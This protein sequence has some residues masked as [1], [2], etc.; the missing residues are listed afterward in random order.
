AITSWRRGRSPAL[1]SL[2]CHTVRPPRC[3]RR[4]RFRHRRVVMNRRG[5]FATATG[6]AIA[7]TVP[8]SGLVAAEPQVRLRELYEKDM[9]FTPFAL[10]NAGRRVAIEGFMAPP[11]KADSNFYVLT[12]IPMA[13]CPFCSSEAE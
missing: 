1:S 12:N 3:Y 8:L 11:L 9:S 7:A 4:V 2:N 5:F 10:E 6:A 13:V